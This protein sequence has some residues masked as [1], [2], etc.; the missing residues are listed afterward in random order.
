MEH[1]LRMGGYAAF[2]WPSYALAL[3]V[4]GWNVWAARRLHSAALQ[5]ALRRG[6]PQGSQP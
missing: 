2:V 4:L 1:F 5:R 6:A 3:A